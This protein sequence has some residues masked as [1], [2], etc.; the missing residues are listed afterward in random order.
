MNMF[1]VCG[2]FSLDFWVTEV[3]CH[4]EGVI[5]FYFLKLALT[6]LLLQ[7]VEFDLLQQI[8]IYDSGLS[9]NLTIISPFRNFNFWPVTVLQRLFI[10]QMELVKEQ[11]FVVCWNVIVWEMHRAKSLGFSNLWEDFFYDW[12]KIHAWNVKMIQELTFFQELLQD[13]RKICLLT[14]NAWIFAYVEISD[15]WLISSYNFK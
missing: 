8:V 9:R 11:C 7:N 3:P 2:K 13:C 6:T 12:S 14:C 15:Q 1:W 10:A 4:D 5:C